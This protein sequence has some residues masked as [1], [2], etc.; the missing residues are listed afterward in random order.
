M[1]LTHIVAASRNQVI[2]KDNLLPWNIPEDLKFFRD[3]TKNHI[4]IM[5]RKTFESLPKVL[6]SRFHIVISRNPTKT[7]HP[8][9]AYTIS[10]DSALE[11]AKEQLK[12]STNT[13]GNEVFIIG[14]GEIFR[15]TMSQVD[16]I[17]LTQINQ[18]YDGDAFYPTVDP[19]QFFL[20]E[21]HPGNQSPRTLNSPEDQQNPQYSFLTY[22]RRK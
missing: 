19:N 8:D 15:Q 17:Y 18:D 10:V 7:D 14:G 1:I 16:K 12:K 20:Y 2:G 11:I 22:L 6:P 21:E 9:V 4:M 13:W 3:K 5:G